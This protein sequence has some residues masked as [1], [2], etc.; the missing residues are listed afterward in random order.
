MH[1]LTRIAALLLLTHSISAQTFHGPEDPRL[2]IQLTVQHPI[3]GV[4]TTPS[5]RLFV[6]YA[7]VDGSKG[8]QV[9]EYDQSTNT[10]TA[11][12][13]LEWNSYSD[14]DDPATHFLGVNSQRIG[15]DGKLYIVDKGGTA[16]GVPIVLP[17][18]PKLV[19]VDLE[20]NTVS[21]IYYMGNVTRSNS[22]LDDVRFNPAKDR[23][24]LTDAGSPGLIVL[25]LVTGSA[26]RVLDGMVN[27]FATHYVC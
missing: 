13:N 24:Y 14:G 1:F 16:L 21:R 8:P 20:T 4:S 6:V 10:S 5:G 2:T 7:R 19:Q 17:Y 9:A 15:P 11:Y 18:G 23:A 12:P 3:N 25:D 26:V 27:G 22:L